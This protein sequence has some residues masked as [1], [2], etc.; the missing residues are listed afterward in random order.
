M[1]DVDPRLT[2]PLPPEVKREIRAV[3]AEIRQQLQVEALQERRTRALVFVASAACAAL[4]LAGI[5]LLDPIWRPYLHAAVALLTL[6]CIVPVRSLIGQ[7]VGDLRRNC[8]DSTF[9]ATVN[10]TQ[11]ACSNLITLL[12]FAI[13]ALVFALVAPPGRGESGA[14]LLSASVAFALPQNWYLLVSAL[15]R[16]AEMEA[17]R[18]R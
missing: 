3:A 11:R 7:V 2:E 6:T 13:G 10:I 16:R 15:D 4:F 1:K 14:I 12:G 8:N 18:S 9:T 17:S 5:F